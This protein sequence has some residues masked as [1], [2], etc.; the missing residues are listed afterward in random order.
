MHVDEAE[1]YESTAR[2][3]GDGR[4]PLQGSAGAEARTAASGQS[5]PETKQ[6]MERVLERENMQA[7]YRRVMSN[8]GAPG[9]DGR[10]VSGLKSWL[11][12]RWPV[13]K[14]DLLS[15]KYQ[16]Q[17]LRKVEIAKPQGGVRTLG[18][19]TVID[20]LIQQALHQVLSPIF[21]PAFSESSYGF[22]PGRSAQQAVKAARGYVAK[23]KRWVVNLDLEKFFDRVN[24]DILMSR[25]ARK[26]GD[27][28]VLKLIRRYLQ[29]GLM[30]G[31]IETVRGQGTPQGGPLSPLLSNILLDDLDR[32]LER[33]QLSFCRYADDCN[34]YVGSR[35][36]GERTMRAMT[37]FLERRLKLQV[38]A[39]KSAVARPWARKFLGYSLTWHKQPKL[40]IAPQSRQRFMDK[41]RKLMRVCRGKS[42]QQTIEALNP[43][44]RG[45]VQYFRLVEVKT[46]LEQLDGWVRHRLRSLV[47][48]Q[49][50]SARKRA[51][52]LMKLGIAEDIAWL[53][54]TDRRGPWW[55]GAA[56]H[57]HQ[58]YPN[59]TFDQMGLVSLLALRKRLTAVS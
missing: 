49:W 6:L 12:E 46:I 3:A 24:H 10:P 41:I 8:Q 47:W 52:S 16:P 5:K 22:R 40:R 59:K 33:R 27:E 14:E 43:V 45:W 29:A 20:R 55:H 32:E 30:E 54:A 11:I 48:R 34:I 44:L 15:G 7:A 31:G 51:H 23:G 42:L 25:L 38:N 26:V 18:I 17:G 37:A 53:S 1:A 2:G 56:R 39:D 21:D 13:V 28:R 50:K 19:P 58:A 4:N 57:M 36:S 35:V 9:V